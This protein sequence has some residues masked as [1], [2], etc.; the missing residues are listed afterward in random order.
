MI[1]TMKMLRWEFLGLFFISLFLTWQ[2][3]DYISWWQ[4]I[5]LFFLIDIIGYYPGRI[6]S[7]LNK[8]EV[9]PAGFYTVYN[10]CHNLFTISIMSLLWLWLFKD[11]YSVIALFIH[12]CLDRGV[13]GNFPK[14]SINVFKQPTV[15]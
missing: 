11:N 2:F 6:W 8:K 13:L 3:V 1:N 15:H 4:F 7:L 9:P 14:L 5:L 10:I 12:I